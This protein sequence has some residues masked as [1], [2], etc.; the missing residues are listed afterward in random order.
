MPG[1]SN[2][3]SN[4]PLRGEVWLVDLDPT[5]GRGQAGRRPALVVSVGGFNRGPAEL[6]M[7]LPITSKDKRIRSHVRVE[8]PMGGLTMTSFVKCEEIRT[9]SKE[10]LIS[11]MGAVSAGV[12]AE[13][14][15]RLGVLLGL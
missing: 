13:I 1:Q 14:E 15:A 11:R 7:I 8:P 2:P 4:D 3:R 5:R 6:V 10:R 9:I 12:L